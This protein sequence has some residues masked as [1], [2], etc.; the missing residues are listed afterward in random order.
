MENKVAAEKLVYTV[1]ETTKRCDL[2]LNSNL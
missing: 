1:A 2:G